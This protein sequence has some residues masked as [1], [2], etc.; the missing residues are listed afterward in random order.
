MP[1]LSFD[2]LGIDLPVHGTKTI[3]EAA[4]EELVEIR[5]NCGGL[6]QCTTCRVQLLSGA[7]SLD[8][9]NRAELER[10]GAH[11]LEK[12]WRLACQTVIRKDVTI[13]LPRYA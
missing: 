10:L 6:G 12:G 3:L 5:H 1:I 13:R 9:P 7:D 4:L 8:P 11:R 2:G